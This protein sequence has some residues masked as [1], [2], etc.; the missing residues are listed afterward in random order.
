M[1]QQATTRKHEIDESLYSRQLYVLGHDA[2]KR[3]LSS[4]VLLLGMGGL[5]VEIAKNLVLAGVHSLV[6]YD[7]TL[8]TI[9]DFGSQVLRLNLRLVLPHREGHRIAA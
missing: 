9:Q 2:M 1:P 4:S 5:G 3:M 8:V 7:E 6:I